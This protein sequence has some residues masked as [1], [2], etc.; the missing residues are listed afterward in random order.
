LLNNVGF[1]Y[2]QD[3]LNREP[4]ERWAQRLYERIDESDVFFLFWSTAAKES[5]WV[6]K[7]WRYALE[8]KGD[9]F[10]HPVG[11]EGPPIP[12][13]PDELKHIHFGDPLL[14]FIRS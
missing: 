8:N 10:I 5:E 9:D 1:S 4:G 14:Y 13:P 2:F 7:E 3:I 11:L 12:E 6:A